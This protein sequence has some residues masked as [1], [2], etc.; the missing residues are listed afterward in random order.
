LVDKD[1]SVKTLLFT[2]RDPGAAAAIAPIAAEAMKMA[3]FDIYIYASEPAYS[4]LKNEGL[5]VEKF[6]SGTVKSSSDT[7][8]AALLNEAKKILKKIKPD[9][10]VVGISGPDLG[11]DEAVTASSTITSIFAI[12]DYSGWVVDAFGKKANHYFVN[13][14]FAR[15][16]TIKHKDINVYV[17]G[18]TRYLKYKNIR[19]EQ[20]LVYKETQNN[21]VITFYGQPILSISGYLK[22]LGMLADTIVEMP[23]NIIFNYRPH[24]IESSSDI[25]QIVNLFSEKKCGVVIEKDISLEE[26]LYSCDI[27]CTCFSTCGENHVFLSKMSNKP[28]GVLMYLMVDESLSSYLAD[29]TG[30]DIPVPGKQGLALVARKSHEIS[31]MITEALKPETKLLF[32]DKIQKLIECPDDAAKRILNTINDEIIRESRVH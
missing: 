21:S 26:S 31:I 13:D 8:C 5:C 9:G 20:Q 2:A 28:L 24:P 11:I 4:I 32:W 30:L 29:N 18:S 3:V 10:V 16:A 12:Q 25:Q 7:N 27:A 23:T 6:C 1:V 14:E 22:A 15:E 17:S 19:R